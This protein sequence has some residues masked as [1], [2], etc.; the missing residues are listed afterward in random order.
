[1]GTSN[2][3]G[4]SSGDK[5]LLPSWIDDAGGGP[6]PV[7][8][9][10]PP[11][12]PAPAPGMPPGSPPPGVPTPT[13]SIPAPAPSAPAAP[14][15]P[16]AP[17]RF[18]A[19]RANFTRFASSGGGDRKSLGRAIAGYVRG[20]KGGSA[21][22]ARGMGASRRAGGSLVSFLNNAQTNGAQT[23]LRSLDLDALA[24]RPVEDIF[25]SLIHI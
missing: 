10:P 17:D 19:P 13:P 14:Q 7:P 15:S 24:G 23:A 3:F 22:A 6:P 4:G 1:M 25:L 11:A 9:V 21:T 2:S 16:A 20:A 12:D 5:P 18:T 8:P